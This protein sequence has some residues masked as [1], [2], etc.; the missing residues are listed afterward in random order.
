MTTSSAPAKPKAPEPKVKSRYIPQ[1]ILPFCEQSLLNLALKGARVIGPEGDMT[2]SLIAK[3]DA[4]NA[5]YEKALRKLRNTK[6]QS[7]PRKATAPPFD[8][9]AKGLTHKPEVKP[10][11]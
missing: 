2:D 9:K 4:I 7:A 6:G 5:E 8:P 3:A 1:E 11:S 10:K